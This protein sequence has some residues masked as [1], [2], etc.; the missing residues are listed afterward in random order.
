MKI[1]R[2][3]GIAFVALI[4]LALELLADPV[5][6]T[7]YGTLV[8]LTDDTASRVYTDKAWENGKPATKL[9]DNGG[10]SSSSLAGFNGAEVSV[11]YTF[12]AATTVNA[13]GLWLGTVLDRGPKDW[14]FSGSN[15]FDGKDMSKAT[16]VTL[17]TRT[18]ETEWAKY[19]RNLYR[20]DNETAYRSYRLSF[21]ATGSGG[22]IQLS[23]VEFY[24]SP[25]TRVMLE[26]NPRPVGDDAATA[27]RETAAEAGQELT[28][29]TIS[30]QW[31]NAAADTRATCTG[32]TLYKWNSSSSQW[33]EWL[34]GNASSVTITV[35]SEN[36]KIIWNYDYNFPNA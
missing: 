12:D 28:L 2:Q 20:C 5:N 27:Y 22:R 7:A 14:T 21:T 31:E 15:D 24:Y 35:P 9:F 23:E 34:S 13:Y 33:D 29:S 32:Y 17:D 19:T 3:L 11:V 1:T 10:T 6:P 4:A 25:L 36:T 18:G 26:A 8:D 30:G 16:W